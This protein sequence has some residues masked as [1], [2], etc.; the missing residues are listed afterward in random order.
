MKLAGVEARPKKKFKATTDSK[1]NLPVAPNLLKRDFSTKAPGCV[2]VGDV[3]YIWTKEGW[4]Y[5]AVVIDLFSRRVVGWALNRRMTKQLAID[6]L[7]M[8]IWRVKPI[9]GAMFH[10]D[11]GS[12]YCSH[13]FQRVL[14]LYGMRSSMSR[15][16]DCWD[17]AVAESFFGT[18]K[19]ELVFGEIFSTRREAI[20]EVID[21]I[22]MFYNNHR[23][24]SFLEYLPPIEFEKRWELKTAA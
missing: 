16:G 1:H 14:R 11:R 13:A 2:L 10:S 9:K 23:L 6:A 15:K 17:N 12:Q 5:L 19:T 21:Y 24:H 8:A 7:L 20:A 18:L 4:L 22:E 3:T